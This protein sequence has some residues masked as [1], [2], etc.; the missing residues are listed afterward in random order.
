MRQHPH[1]VLDHHHGAFHDHAEVE[2]AQRQQ[3]RRNVPQVEADGGEQQRERNGQRD[4]QR[5]ADIAQEDEQDHRNQD[6][7]F[8]QV[9]HHRAGGQM[10][11]VAAVE[12]RNDLHAGRK[13]VIVQLL[14]LG[15]DRL[16]RG[17]RVGALPQQHDAR[18]H[19]VVVEDLPVRAVNGPA[20]L[21]EP[22]FGSLLARW[23]C[24][25]PAARCRSWW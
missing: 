8:G 21:A 9:V 10:Q 25:S 23:R 24:P 19:V 1:D 22:D 3:I 11:E 16:E 5:A 2:R 18:H 20:E 4:D 17:I 14:H 13:N 12:E 15:V 6:D 7:A